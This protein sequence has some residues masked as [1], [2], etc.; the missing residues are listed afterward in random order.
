[1]ESQEISLTDS[2]TTCEMVNYMSDNLA[3]TDSR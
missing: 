1:M 3:R 2:S